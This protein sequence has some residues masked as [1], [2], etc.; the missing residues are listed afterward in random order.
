MI[1]IHTAS[2]VT[3]MAN[4]HTFRYRTVRLL[5]C[6]TMSP[7]LLVAIT[8]AAIAIGMHGSDK[9]KATTVRFRLRLFR[10]ALSNGGASWHVRAPPN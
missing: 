1:D 4:Q 7:F 2:N 5:P 6:D 9:Q 10:K 8:N 3:L